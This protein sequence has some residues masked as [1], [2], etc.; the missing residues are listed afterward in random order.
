MDTLRLVT[1]I[2]LGLVMCAAG[3]SKIRMGKAWIAQGRELGAPPAVL[4]IVPWIE[5]A[6]GALL[7]AQV[8]T[9]AV[10]IVALVVLQLFTL[11]LIV[12][13]GRGHRPPCACF[14]AWSAKP[15]G[16]GHVARNAVFMGLA[17]LA[18]IGAIA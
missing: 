4:P 12:N 3:A 16:W 5:M 17:V 10:A 6:I 1:S 15:L 18:Y 7:I 8:A 11:L 13:L 14:G 2:A 9:A